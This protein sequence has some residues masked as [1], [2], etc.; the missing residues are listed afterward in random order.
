MILV[1]LGSRNPNKVRGTELAFR[2]AGFRV[3]V[4]PIEPPG[5][6]SPEPLVLTKPFT[7]LLGGRNTRLMRYEMP[8]SALVL[9]LG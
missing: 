6:L 2:L 1:A 3:S 4:V 8:S 5:D 7:G 9:R